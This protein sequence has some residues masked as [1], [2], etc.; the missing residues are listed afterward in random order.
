MFIEN[1]TIGINSDD[2]DECTDIATLRKWL[3]AVKED[4]SR[5]T[6]S[7]EK[8]Y[9]SGREI[10]E[11]RESNSMTAKK[12]QGLLAYRIQ[13]RIATLKD[14]L[15]RNDFSNTFMDVA[16]QR[17]PSDDFNTIFREAKLIHDGF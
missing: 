14:T 4:I 1:K 7:L 12:L 6:M 16:R 2:V 11:E 15:P 9:E 13:E 17:L 10:D 3:V 5:I 8:A